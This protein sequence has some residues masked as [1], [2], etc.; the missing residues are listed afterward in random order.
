MG[1]VAWN[2][3]YD[4]MMMKYT[5]IR[6]VTG[7]RYLENIPEVQVCRI[8]NHIRWYVTSRSGISSPGELLSP[9]LPV[10]I[11]R[12]F[13]MTLDIAKICHT[14]IRFLRLCSLKYIKIYFDVY[15][16][17]HWQY[18]N[19]SETHFNHFNAS[20]VWRVTSHNEAVKRM[21]ALHAV[22]IKLNRMTAI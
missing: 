19:L 6:N 7:T 12:L 3:G 17:Q 1:H 18:L 4:D 9:K 13:S 21:R 22:Y 8:S 16:S 11:L 5:S 2:K 14:C 15:T 20:H 10:R